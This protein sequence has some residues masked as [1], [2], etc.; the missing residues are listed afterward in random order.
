MKEFK[1]FY[2]EIN[3]NKDNIKSTIELLKQ[4]KPG[5]NLINAKGKVIKDMFLVSVDD[6][7]ATYLTTGKTSKLTQ[8][9]TINNEKHEILLFKD[10]IG[11]L[12]KL[13]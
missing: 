12:K 7:V 3:E 8:I 10:S 2:G 13:L 1:E 4:V 6:M 5:E 11:I 9:S